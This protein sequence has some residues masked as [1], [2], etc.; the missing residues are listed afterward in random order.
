[1]KA[2]ERLTVSNAAVGLTVAIF[3]K[4]SGLECCDKATILV[5]DASIRYRVDG[6]DPTTTIGLLANSGDIISLSGISELR[7]FKA[8]RTATTDAHLSCDYGVQRPGGK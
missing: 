1:M 4:N 3:S 5:E 2:F 7:L 8:I 6:S